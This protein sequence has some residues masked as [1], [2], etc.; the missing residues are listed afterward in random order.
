MNYI[1]RKPTL[2][3]DIASSA[4]LVEKLPKSVVTLGRSLKTSEKS[5]VCH[6]V[7]HFS[8]FII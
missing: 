1:L 2:R 7:S 8:K 3:A 4:A 5:N 6:F